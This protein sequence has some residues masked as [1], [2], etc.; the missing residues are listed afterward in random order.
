MNA[1][2]DYAH[3]QDHALRTGR[4]VLR[5]TPDNQFTDTANSVPKHDAL[6]AY[7][8]LLEDDDFV[9]VFESAAP[10]TA[11]DGEYMF[12]PLVNNIE[13]AG[14]DVFVGETAKAPPFVAEQGNTPFARPQELPRSA[15]NAL[16]DVVDR[17]PFKVYLFESPEDAASYA[18][19][20][21]STVKS[22]R[23]AVRSLPAGDDM[24][25]APVWEA[26]Q[27][28]EDEVNWSDLVTDEQFIDSIKP[29]RVGITADD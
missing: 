18:D 4:Y 27:K 21:P 19:A 16:N 6:I 28:P 22:G 20:M 3:F 12:K 13:D 26:G 15:E 25:K 24:W 23:F 1:A 11:E 14:F 29:D 9:D 10:Q 2:V 7:S 8:T 17:D 5:S